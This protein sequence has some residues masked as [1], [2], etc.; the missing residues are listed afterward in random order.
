MQV[1]KKHG[2]EKYQSLG[3]AFDPN[4]H[5]AVFEVQDAAKAPGTIAMELKVRLSAL[6]RCREA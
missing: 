6:L 2:L 3:E 5:S 4:R 1:F